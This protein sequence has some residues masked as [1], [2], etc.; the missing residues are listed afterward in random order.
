MSQLWQ[1]LKTYDL[2][3][4]NMENEIFNK[5]KINSTTKNALLIYQI[6]IIFCTF[7]AIFLKKLFLG[8]FLNGKKPDIN[9]KSY[10]F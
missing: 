6:I 8:K 2:Y 9:K 10:Q 4:Q 1:E 5:D 7:F 3:S